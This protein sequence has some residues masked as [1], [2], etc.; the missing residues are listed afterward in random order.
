MKTRCQVTSEPWAIE[1]FEIMEKEIDIF[2]NLL[3]TMN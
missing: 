1:R 3:M 2:G